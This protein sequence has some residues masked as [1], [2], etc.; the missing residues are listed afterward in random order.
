MKCVSPISSQRKNGLS[1]EH[2][3]L[4]PNHSHFP[5]ISFWRCNSF[6][7]FHA[8]IKSSRLTRYLS[9]F[10]SAYFSLKLLQSRPSKTF[11]E[12]LAF[13][14][15]NGIELR[16]TRFAGRT[17]DLTLFSFTRAVDCIVGELWARR[18]SQRQISGR[19]SRVSFPTLK[20]F[21]KTLLTWILGR[22]NNLIPHRPSFVRHILCFNNVG[23]HLHTRSSS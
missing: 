1:I 6:P 22:Q 9:T 8:D 20:L 19:W 2:Y 13:E 3:T 14:T 18:K 15:K 10:I 16:P 7:N 23:F 12:D 11:T 17:L 4:D 21:L 5:S